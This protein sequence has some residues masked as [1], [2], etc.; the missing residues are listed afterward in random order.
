MTQGWYLERRHRWLPW[1]WTQAGW[2]SNV[3]TI[4]WLHDDLLAVGAAETH[5]RVR[6]GMVP[7]MGYSVTYPS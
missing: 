1:V 2:A 5:L 3:V 4:W 7:S 6:A